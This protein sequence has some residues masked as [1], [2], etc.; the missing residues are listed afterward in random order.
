MCRVDLRVEEVV[1]D[2]G[3]DLG[4]HA[5]VLSR[6]ASGSDVWLVQDDFLD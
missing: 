4:A 5:N 1:L 3:K 6:I 2:V